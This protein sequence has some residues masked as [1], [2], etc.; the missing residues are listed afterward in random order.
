M[1]SLSSVLA[2]ASF[3]YKLDDS[4]TFEFVDGLFPSD[5][6]PDVPYFYAP[7][8]YAWWEGNT[9][10][11]VRTSHTWLQSK[12]ARDGPYDGVL[13]FSQ[14]CS[15][16]ASFLL[17]HQAT[18]PTSP[19]PFKVAIFICGGIPLSILEDL[20]AKVSQEAHDWDQKTRV[21]LREKTTDA[22]AILSHG[23]DRWGS[24]AKDDTAEEDP[25]AKIMNNP[26]DVFGLDTTQFSEHSK[27][28][29]PTVHIY[30]SKDPRRPASLQLACLCRAEVRKIYDHGGGHDIPR[31]KEVSEAI[32][33]L[34][35]WSVK[36]AEGDE[37]IRA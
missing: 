4:I 1:N 12:L 9:P 22:A 26:Q 18:N 5:P 16:I 31:R 24:S 2:T 8:Y 28:R 21:L 27:I 3:R 11:S 6:A 36:M 25:G 37:G 14:G 19:P 29:I 35:R 23:H 17:Y 10:A 7:P 32:A 15:V 34:V 33:G 13:L 30:G 20:G